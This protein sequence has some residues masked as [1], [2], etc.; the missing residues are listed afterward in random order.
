MH[1]TDI[2]PNETSTETKMQKD[3][4]YTVKASGYHIYDSLLKVKSGNYRTEEAAL[5]ECRQMEIRDRYLK[6]LDS[7]EAEAGMRSRGDG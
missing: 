4:R 3:K 7:W 6:A 1:E 2:S 5:E